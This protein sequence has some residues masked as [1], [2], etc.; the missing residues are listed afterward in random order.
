MDAAPGTLRDPGQLT[1]AIGAPPPPRSPR[2]EALEKWRI[3]SLGLP[4]GVVYMS[5]T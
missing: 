3:H 5:A 4:T 2:S 1:G